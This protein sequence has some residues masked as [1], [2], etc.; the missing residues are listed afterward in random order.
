MIAV[1]RPLALVVGLG[2]LLLACDGDEDGAGPAD[3]AGAGG[4]LAPEAGGGGARAGAGAGG[5]SAGAGSGG[6]AGRA[7]SDSGSLDAGIDGATDAGMNDGAAPDAGRATLPGTLAETGL[8]VAGSTETLA[9]GVL[10]YTPRYALWSDGASKQRWLLLPAGTQI[11]TS[12][13]DNWVFPVGTKVWKE[14]SNEGK[15]LETRLLWKAERGWQSVAYVWNDAETEAVATPR[16]AP[17]VRGTMHDVPE[18]GAC[19]SC[20]DGRPDFLLGV[21]AIQLAHDGAGATLSSLVADDRLSDPPADTSALA[22]PDTAEWNAL[23]YLH[24]NCG[25]C[26]NPDSEVWDRVDLDLW[27]RVDELDDAESTRSYLSTV[28]VALTDTDTSGGLSVR[29]DPGEPE[30]SGLIQRMRVRGNENAMPPIA[31]ERVDEDGIGV[32]SAWIDD[33]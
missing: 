24:A 33:L 8:Y 25:N 19:S 4:Q 7:G 13:M 2:C 16:G 10:A 1:A 6:S 3:Q 22:L 30:M 28:G 32:L 14:F 11:D 18:R 21:S 27:L 12:D 17:N 23:G 5:A 20:H 15:R 26:H 9:P 29:I 31:S